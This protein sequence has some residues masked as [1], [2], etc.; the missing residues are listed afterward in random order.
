MLP[1]R[2][3]TL[4]CRARNADDARDVLKMLK[5]QHIGE[6]SAALYYEWAALELAGGNQFKAL[7]V[8]SKGLKERAQPARCARWHLGRGE[9]LGQL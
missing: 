5:S 2:P 4:S 1:P 7:G 9:R 8:L 3:T 6:T